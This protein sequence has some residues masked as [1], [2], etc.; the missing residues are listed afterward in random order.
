MSREA[1]LVDL[2]N[3]K[4]AKETAQRLLKAINAK[5]KADEVLN[6]LVGPRRRR[7]FGVGAKVRS[8]KNH[9]PS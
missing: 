4:A 5:I 8:R 1:V 9:V 3:P 2:R 7:R 6:R